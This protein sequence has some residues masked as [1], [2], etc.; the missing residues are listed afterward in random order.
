MNL[1]LLK[2]KYLSFLKVIQIFLLL[3][4]YFQTLF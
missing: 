4:F 3:L 1:F 2:I